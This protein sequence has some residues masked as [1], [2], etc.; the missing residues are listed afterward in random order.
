[1][2]EGV[3]GTPTVELGDPIEFASAVTDA[4]GQ[5][6]TLAQ[7]AAVDGSWY[8]TGKVIEGMCYATEAL[9]VPWWVSIAGVTAGVRLLIFPL[10]VWLESTK[11]QSIV[12]ALRTPPIWPVPLCLVVCVVHRS[13]TP[14]WPE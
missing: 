4:L 12:P 11:V 1:M 9:G 2:A 3:G 6:E 7:T 13:R 14:K 8:L 10:M 5:A